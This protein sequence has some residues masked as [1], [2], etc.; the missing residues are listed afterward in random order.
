MVKKIIM[1][2][3][4]LFA[5][6]WVKSEWNNI[7]SDKEV[8]S[9][10]SLSVNNWV[11]NQKA[12]TV[13]CEEKK[14]DPD[15]KK[16]NAVFQSWI[17]IQS[18]ETSVNDLEYPLEDIK[19]HQQENKF[20]DVFEYPLKEES[21]VTYEEIIEEVEEPYIEGDE[22]I[23]EV[24]K[25][26]ESD[27]TQETDEYSEN[28]LFW[29]SVASQK[30]EFPKEPTAADLISSESTLT[31]LEALMGEDVDKNKEST[32]DVADSYE[33]PTL[34]SAY[35]KRKHTMPEISNP[36]QGAK[37]LSEVKIF[38]VLFLS[39][40]STFFFFTNAKLV[41]IT[42]N[43]FIGGEWN[44]PIPLITG[45]DQHNVADVVSQKQ[46][47]LE[48]L[49]ESFQNIQKYKRE[50]QDIALNM[51][52]F[53]NQQQ[54]SHLLNFN[55]LPP[56]N[57]LIIPDLWIN[58]PLV[59][60]PAMWEEDFE[61]GNFDDELMHGVVKY[62]TTATPGSQGNSLIFWHS[63]SEW[64]KHNEYWFIFRNLPTL[65]PGQKIQVIW[66]WQLTTYEMI[67]RKVVKPK[68]VWDYYHQFVRDWEYYLTL[69]GCYP[70]WS[71]AE[72][73]MVVAKKISN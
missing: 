26:E 59:D 34:Y 43:D 50:E 14:V 2:F 63:S 24:E 73:M 8:F 16:D 7:H 55:T 3:D 30:I 53:L 49:E 66:N 46:E 36:F 65:Q 1:D 28:E 21:S 45:T 54:E 10:E 32:N 29:K 4:E 12:T 64:W 61:N 39:V 19:I 20:V 62:P 33:V 47:K 17:H 41:L 9:E 23:E 58:V 37:L 56:T 31:P 25:V 6:Y 69:M 60:I 27:N 11:V 35:T 57:R 5:L 72:R 40:F 71:S 68:E 70:I 13:F 42:V 51:Q 52:D 15:V 38:I 18:Q 44:T 67:E 48:A 22:E